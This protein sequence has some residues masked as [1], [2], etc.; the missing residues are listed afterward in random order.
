MILVILLLTCCNSLKNSQFLIYTY[1]LKI[2]KSRMSE[3]ITVYRVQHM[4][5]IYL[6]KLISINNPD[7]SSIVCNH[8]TM[9]VCV[10]LNICRLYETRRE[11]LGSKETCF[12]NLVLSN[13]FNMVFHETVSIYILRILHYWRCEICSKIITYLIVCMIMIVVI[14][15]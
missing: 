15:Y 1:F 3:F 9:N 12:E 7:F 8:V 14:M 5:S 2:G 4:V 11:E 13:H 10:L 6:K